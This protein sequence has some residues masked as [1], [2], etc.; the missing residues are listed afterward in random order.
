[1]YWF[2]SSIG[3][4][5]YVGKAKNLKNRIAQYRQ[6][7]GLTAF[8]K[9]LVTEAVN[10]K[11]QVLG[12]ELE[13]LFVEAELIRR[14]LPHYNIRLR[15][16][17]S[18]VYLV[19][20]KEL[21][22]RLLTARRTDLQ[23]PVF[24]GG[25]QFGPFQSSYMLKQVLRSIRSSFGWCNQAGKMFSNEEEWLAKRE[26]GQLRACF[27]AHLGV[28]KGACAGEMTPQDY[29]KMI[30]R[31]KMF[32]RGQTK[33]VQRE[34]KKQIEAAAQEKNYELA[35]QLKQEWESIQGLVS[36]QYRVAPDIALPR[37][38][39]VFGEQASLLL[40]KIV[41]DH[42][43]LPAAWQAH[44]IEGYDVSN[45]QGKYATVSMVVFIDGQP[46][47]QHYRI[48]HIRSK[49]TPDDYGMLAEVLKRRQN[50]PEW[51]QPDLVLID[52]GKGQLGV[53]Q[54]QW[55][56]ENPVVS[57]GKHP[58]RLFLPLLVREDPSP[59]EENGVVATQ[60]KPALQIPID[61]IAQAGQLL[62]Q[63]RD[64]SHRFA[65]RHVHKRL[66]KRDIFS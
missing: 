19:I 2:L 51:G 39:S 21:F 36:E 47:K 58:D 34:L 6:L 42:F 3:S 52:G 35:A 49:D 26:N 40:S 13:A 32:L 23:K 11:C 43:D 27:Y 5:L 45:V 15:D 18:P 37:I 10:V 38:Q 46:A 48:F 66:E 31:L 57:I 65:K 62:Q 41:R 56:W 8:K 12:S 44:R 28:C 29:A 17:K 33:T 54:E 64:E 16:D 25:T 55:H 30:R 22:P 53:G 4:V 59:N 60:V 20:T 9:R 61:R 50:H 24:K 1:M 63:V 7:K 14:H